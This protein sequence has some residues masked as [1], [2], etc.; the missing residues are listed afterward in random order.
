[1]TS[2][3]VVILISYIGVALAGYWLEYLQ[4]S[5]L[6]HYGNV[7]PPEFTGSMDHTLLE[8]SNNYT[9][10]SAH[11]GII[12]SVFNHVVVIVFLFTGIFNWY[13][14]WT[15]S[16]HL[17]FIVA[18]IVFFMLLVYADTVLGIPLGLYKT[19]RIEKKYGFNT[20]TPMLWVT[21]FIKSLIISTVLLSLIIAAGLWLIESSPS[22]WWL[23]VWLLFF[24]FSIFMMYISPYVIEP[25]FNKFQPVEDEA[26]KQGIEELTGKVGVKIS[27][28]L[29]MD[30]SKRTRHTNAY[31]TGIGHVKRVVLF[32]T[33]LGSMTTGE[34]L[35]VLGHEL[36]HWKKKHVFKQLALMETVSFV[37]LLVSFWLMEGRLLLDMFG[38]TTD[39]L[40]A[41]V[42]ILGFLGT[43]VMFPLTPA[44]SL[45]SRK[46]E[47]EADRFACDLTGKPEYMISALVKLSKDNLSNLHPHPLYSAF[48]YSHPPVTERIQRIQKTSAQHGKE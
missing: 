3:A 28:I 10:E 27:K 35:V 22:W 46:H 13:T 1:M 37:V 17:P 15:A 26:L 11:F 5:H 23:W 12:S 9:I 47:Q 4:L 20:M 48:Y 38:I 7:I 24:L 39:T 29:K 30:A 6:K 45:F 2:A 8:R 14:G 31:F 34:I 36:G 40:F 44:F 16:L 18:G 41:K 43:I 33:L 19:F 21:D 32:D 42:V 25:L